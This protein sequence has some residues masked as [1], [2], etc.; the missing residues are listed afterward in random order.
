MMSTCI[1]NSKHST[2][3]IRALLKARF[4]AGNFRVYRSGAIYVHAVQPNESKPRWL[5]FGDIGAA[6][7]EARLDAL[8][9]EYGTG[10]IERLARQVGIR[11]IVVA[12]AHEVPHGGREVRND[13][14]H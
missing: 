8:A 14:V 10:R 7:T 6:D 9:A 11:G 1:R 5:L 3:V 2:G 4:G 13:R 12:V